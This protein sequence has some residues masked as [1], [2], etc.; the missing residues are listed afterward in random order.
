MILLDT[1]LVALVALVV[2]SRPEVVR[3]L[4]ASMA[5]DLQ[6]LALCRKYGLPGAQAQLSS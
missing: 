6:S 4:L 3:A 2:L 5:S 1:T